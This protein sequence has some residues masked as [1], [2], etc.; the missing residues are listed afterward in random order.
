MSLSVCNL[1]QSIDNLCA[2]SCFFC[3]EWTKGNF[4]GLSFVNLWT[5]HW[6][7]NAKIKSSTTFHTFIVQPAAILEPLCSGL[8]VVAKIISIFSTQRI[9][10][11]IQQHSAICGCMFFSGAMHLCEQ[12]PYDFGVSGENDFFIY[13]LKCLIQKNDVLYVFGMAK[14]SRTHET[15][16]FRHSCFDPSSRSSLQF[17]NYFDYIDSHNSSVI[18]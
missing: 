10:M 6:N 12:Q 17:F 8:V 7:I 16:K 13:I 9:L 11:N 5:P 3:K 14:V 1:E 2:T 15:K 18:R 4:S